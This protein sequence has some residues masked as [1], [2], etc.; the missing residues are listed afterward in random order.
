MKNIVFI[1]GV[2]GVGKSTIVSILGEKLREL[3]YAVSCYFEGGPDSPL[4]LCWTAYLTKQKYENLMTL[5]PCL[6]SDFSSNIIFQGEYILLRY[7]IGRRKLYSPDLHNILQK[8]EFCY[9][10]TNIMPLSKFTE[11]FSC[12]WKR[13]LESNEIVKDYVIF[14]ASLVSHMTNDLV[15]NY[16]ATEIEIARHLEI[17]L[18]IIKPLNPIVFYL[19]SQDVAKRLAKAR[20]SRGQTPPTDEQINFWEKRKQL[21]SSVLS[22]LLVETHIKDISNDN[23]DSIIDEIVSHITRQT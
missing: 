20:E 8:N 7:Q 22:R 9:N 6:A 18:N 1:E 10:P 21:D 19:S 3:G 2:S 16:N 15:R 17:L 4:D 13:F 5:Y 23:W 11:V 14:D 12:L